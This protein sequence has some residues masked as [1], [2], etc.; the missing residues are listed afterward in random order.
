MSQ[1]EQQKMRGV[2]EFDAARIIVDALKDLD[3]KRRV[4][5]VRF[6]CESLGVSVSAAVPAMAESSPPID[7]RGSAANQAPLDIRQFTEAKAP[8]SDIQFAAV[9]AY[10]YRFKAPEN[11]RRETIDAGALQDAARLANR[12][13]PT[14]AR[15]TLNNAK[16]SGYLDGAERGKFRLSTVGENLVAITLPEKKE[17]S[18]G[19][20]SRKPRGRGR[21]GNSKRGSPSK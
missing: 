11:K 15:L 19:A 12:S 7:D 8:K 20:R 5:A 18:G 13:V 1:V 14:N 6:A 16:R 9:V 2:N 3:Q 4:L 10:F 17:G 21:G